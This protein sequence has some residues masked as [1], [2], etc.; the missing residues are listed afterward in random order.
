MTVGE[1]VTAYEA[2]DEQ[3]IVTYDKR[4]A[5]LFDEYLLWGVDDPEDALRL[6]VARRVGED[7]IEVLQVE[8]DRLESPGRRR[9][10]GWGTRRHVRHLGE[11]N[12]LHSDNVDAVVHLECLDPRQVATALNRMDLGPDAMASAGSPKALILHGRAASVRA[13]WIV[14]ERLDRLK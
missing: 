3:R 6:G 10:S 1:W 11:L 14:L 8:L 5:E 2:G 7:P 12:D 13:W 9:L 4:T